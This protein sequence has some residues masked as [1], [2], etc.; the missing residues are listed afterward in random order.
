MFLH[1]SAILFTGVAC[2]VGVIR[3]AGGKGACMARDAHGRGGVCMQERRPLKQAVRINWDAF[4]LD[5]CKCYD[6][7]VR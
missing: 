4:L 2:M 3:V 5:Q 7:Q 6:S 1:L